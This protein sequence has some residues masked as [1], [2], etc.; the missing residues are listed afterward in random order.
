MGWFSVNKPEK[1]LN[2]INDEI[3]EQQVALLNAQL[4]AAAA[5]GKLEVLLVAKAQL[6]KEI[7]PEVPSIIMETQ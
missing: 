1:R 5:K 7:P 2:D 4:Q 3:H 6:E